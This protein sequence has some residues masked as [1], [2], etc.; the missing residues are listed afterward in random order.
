MTHTELEKTYTD[1][2]LNG[3]L[4]D[5]IAYQDSVVD[6]IDNWQFRIEQIQRYID[7]AKKFEGEFLNG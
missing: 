6:L 5:D 3:D 7:H 1:A 4:L 2:G